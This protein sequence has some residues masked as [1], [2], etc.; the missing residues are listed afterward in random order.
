MTGQN[1]RKKDTL[2]HDQ[3]LEKQ[4]IEAG[5]SCNKNSKFLP[6]LLLKPEWRS[7]FWENWSL[8][9]LEKSIFGL[10]CFEFVQIDN[11]KGDSNVGIGVNIRPIFALKVSKDN[12]SFDE[13]A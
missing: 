2:F 1:C 5:L 9:F 8:K 12:K 11:S 6:L 10:F 7:N 13:T 3:F 4:A